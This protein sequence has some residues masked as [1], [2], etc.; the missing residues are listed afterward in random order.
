[1]PSITHVPGNTPT[2]PGLTVITEHVFTRRFDLSE[3]AMK[4]GKGL[5]AGVIAGIVVGA[6]AGIA[7]IAALIFLF[8]RRRKA[9]RMSQTPTRPFSGGE[10][11]V[12]SPMSAAHELASPQ[13]M[14]HS[15]GSNRSA[16]VSPS[17]P[18]AYEQNTELHRTKT[19][20]SA[21]ELPGSTFIFEHHPAYAGQEGG[22][23]V[24]APSSPPRTPAR[25]P[26]GSPHAKTTTSPHVVS[27]LGS[28]KLP[29]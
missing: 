10:M 2:V 9:Q 1:M 23:T 3:E 14:P 25:S 15:P 13:S 26:P 8:L 22:S 6:V 17:S 27:P 11:V 7:I 28:P 18:P 5:A 20:Q 29:Q 4:G 19:P 16:W 24:T 12:A 21:Q